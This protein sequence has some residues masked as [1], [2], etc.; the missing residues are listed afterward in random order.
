MDVNI[1][2]TW[3][4]EN[5]KAIQWKNTTLIFNWD[6]KKWICCCEMWQIW[7][8]NP[9]VYLRSGVANKTVVRFT[10]EWTVRPTSCLVPVW[11]L[12]SSTDLNY[13]LN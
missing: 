12:L 3:M 7:Q 13:S 9:C 11:L 1:D 2:Y 4:E 8:Q 10:L 5:V 6:E